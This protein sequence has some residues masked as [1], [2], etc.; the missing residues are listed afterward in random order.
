MPEE[1]EIAIEEAKKLKEDVI[2]P[3][4]G[5]KVG[6]I[7]VHRA[8]LV[9]SKDLEHAYL[10]QWNDEREDYDWKEIKWYRKK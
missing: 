6:K 1:V 3:E 7:P 9:L 8:I 4:T 5:K 10:L 2:D